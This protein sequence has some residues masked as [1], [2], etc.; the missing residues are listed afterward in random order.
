M[1]CSYLDSSS[2]RLFSVLPV[3]CISSSSSSAWNIE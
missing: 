1:S 2:R 3:R